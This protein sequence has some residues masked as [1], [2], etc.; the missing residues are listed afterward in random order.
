MES[1]ALTVLPQSGNTGIEIYNR[2]AD[3]LSAIEKLGNWFAKSGMFGCDKTEQGQVLAMECLATNKPPSVIARTYHIMD[4][5]LSK[6][7][8][9]ALAEFNGIGGKHRWI[10][11]GD[12]GKE[13]E[14]ELTL[15]GNTITSRFTID[16]AKRMG[17][18]RD[19]GNWIKS[20]GNML[21][22]RCASNGVAMLAPGIFAG[23]VE[24]D[25]P[26]AAPA[27]PLLPPKPAVVTSAP[28]E[29]AAPVVDVQVVEDQI[30]GA[31]MPPVAAAEVKPVTFTAVASDSGGITA[32]TVE[33]LTAHVGKENLEALWNWCVKQ[34]WLT[35]EQMIHA[36]RADRAQKILSANRVAILSKIGG[37]K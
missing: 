16:D 27:A 37:A 29:V 9:A 11:T 3:P 31:E 5:K 7:A 12:D 8:L 6:K 15:D 34:T 4:G 36:L 26:A 14:L 13:A 1:K 33:A 10:K 35:S 23:D 19:R 2:M 20:P 25:A 21:R 30:P 22:A 32:E 24:D 17:L 28:A 18:V